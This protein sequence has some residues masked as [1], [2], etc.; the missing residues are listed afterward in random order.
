MLTLYFLEERSLKTL[1]LEQK[2]SEMSSEI[3]ESLGLKIYRVYFKNEGHE[4]VLHIEITKKEGVGLNDI[5]AFTEI[6]NPKL[7]EMSELDFQYSLDCSSPGAERFFPIEELNEHVDEYMEITHLG[8][9][10]LG[11]LK[12]INE[13]EILMTYFIKGRPKKEKIQIKDISKCQLKVKL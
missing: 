2:I 8:K 5:V 4:K 1:E 11:T 13:E 9:V 12:E 10:T 7:D 3:A 6:I